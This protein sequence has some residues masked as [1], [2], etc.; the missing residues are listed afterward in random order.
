[1]SNRTSEASKAVSE[2]WKHEQELVREGKGTRD[3]TPEQQRD[4][5]ERGKAY[6]E[7]T[8]NSKDEHNRH[9]RERAFGGVQADSRKP[10]RLHSDSP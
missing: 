10:V 8:E 5:L 2:A 6:D 3:W 9:R 4:I 7:R 1:M